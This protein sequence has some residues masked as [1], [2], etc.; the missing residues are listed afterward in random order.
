MKKRI[1]L[2]ASLILVISSCNEDCRTCVVET[3][4]EPIN[5]H[6]IDYPKKT[7]RF[8]R[9]CGQD[10]QYYNNRIEIDTLRNEDLKTLKTVKITCPN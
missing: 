3:T 2:I 10:F 9:V 4:L 7:M 5:F 6:S 1:A 8:F